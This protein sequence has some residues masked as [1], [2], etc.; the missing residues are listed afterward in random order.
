[1]RSKLK[2]KQ[3][4]GEKK[5]EKKNPVLDAMFL[6]QKFSDNSSRFYGLT[7]SI[8]QYSMCTQHRTAQHIGHA[9]KQIHKLS[10]SKFVGVW[11]RFTT[12][13]AIELARAVDFHRFVFDFAFSR[14]VSSSAADSFLIEL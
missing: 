9:Y 11:I 3:N 14:N 4:K 12:A 13:A 6:L 5:K 10:S 7:F 2:F 8:E 1:M